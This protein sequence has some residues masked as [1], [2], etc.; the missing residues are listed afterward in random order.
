MAAGS[1]F[2]E[3]QQ[4]AKAGLNPATSPPYPALKLATPKEFSP[5]LKQN[6]VADVCSTNTSGRY[7][8]QMAVL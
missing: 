7:L 2:G 1:A 4:V 5:Q 3:K 6:W 8:S